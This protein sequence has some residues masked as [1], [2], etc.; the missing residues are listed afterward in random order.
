MKK[1]VPRP[2]F[3]VFAV[4]R[5]IFHYFSEFSVFL[6]VCLSE[7]QIFGRILTEKSQFFRQFL[8]GIP[9]IRQIS[10]AHN[11]IAHFADSLSSTP[12]L[13]QLDAEN[14]RIETLSTIPDTVV[15]V[16]LAGNF[17]K[18][19]P[20]A[21]AALPQL[22]AL[23][24][25]RNEIENGGDNLTVIGEESENLKVFRQKFRKKNHISLNK[26]HFKA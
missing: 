9:A 8:R 13:Q 5:P 19:I 22:V 1:L 17:L 12:F 26:K 10:V 3:V 24:V 2:N 7:N 16:N 23:N 4:F 25:S 14:N 18:M 15:H 21:V 20:D 11:S 6:C